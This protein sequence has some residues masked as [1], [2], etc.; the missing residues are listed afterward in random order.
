MRSRALPTFLLLFALGQPL[1]HAQDSK[2]IDATTEEVLSGALQN[3]PCHLLR[4]RVSHVFP[5]YMMLNSDDR[6]LPGFP[7]SGFRWDT[8]AWSNR[9]GPIGMQ[10]LEWQ[11][12]RDGKGKFILVPY[13]DEDNS[14]GGVDAWVVYDVYRDVKVLGYW[15]QWGRP[16]TDPAGQPIKY[17]VV[18]DD[19]QKRAYRQARQKE[20]FW[21][22]SSW[23]TLG[24]QTPYRTTYQERD[25]LIPIA[26][27]QTM[28]AHQLTTE[29]F[30]QEICRP[31]AVWTPA[32]IASEVLPTQSWPGCQGEDYSDP[33]TSPRCL[34]N[35]YLADERRLDSW[36][37][38]V[39]T[40]AIVPVLGT[41]IK[42]IDCMDTG[43]AYCWGEAAVSGV[44]D[45]A[46]IFVPVA[47]A[48]AASRVVKVAA[49]GKKLEIASKPLMGL[50]VV[51]NTGL[52]LMAAQDGE[53][54]AALSRFAV[55]GAFAIQFRSVAAGSGRLSSFRRLR[56]KT[57]NAT[58][59]CAVPNKTIDPAVCD[60]MAGVCRTCILRKPMERASTFRDLIA[61]T[62]EW[63]TGA[64]Y[65]THP[66]RVAVGEEMFR[67]VASRYVDMNDAVRWIMGVDDSVFLSHRGGILF[68]STVPPGATLAQRGQAFSQL[69]SQMAAEVRAEID[70]MTPAGGTSQSWKLYDW[71]RKQQQLTHHAGSSGTI[72]DAYG[73]AFTA[74]RKLAVRYADSL[75]VP[76]DRP[77]YMLHV[78]PRDSGY[79]GE[80]LGTTSAKEAYRIGFVP[81]DDAVA[82]FVRPNEGAAWFMLS[83]NDACSLDVFLVTG[84]DLSNATRLGRVSKTSLGLDL[85]SLRQM[86]PDAEVLADAIE[87]GMLATPKN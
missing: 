31:I 3:M 7:V 73:L 52:G 63:Q 80:R 82:L 33:T 27:G 35:Y 14:G 50:A 43:D 24:H 57:Q 56:G 17:G 76:L 1:A 23:R 48:A 53:V 37:R 71:A 16:E 28:Y 42:V 47:K 59:N 19:R 46:S 34:A 21:F 75:D 22:L 66:I 72:D 74:D 25:A 58:P 77:R 78:K 86:H 32:R 45:V 87:Q 60:D 13:D 5:D 4:S 38:L 61:E 51:G 40:S 36:K 29:I 85:A 79:I 62:A 6:H 2:K 12:Y 84:D 64:P 67:G 54:L 20:D 44:T 10:A 69:T 39:K 8:S 26:P 55:A 18:T 68:R 9:H 83:R 70:A 81:S 30:V 41:T 49:V 65:S 11:E 15:D